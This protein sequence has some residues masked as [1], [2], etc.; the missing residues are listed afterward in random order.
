MT[1]KDE[2]VLAEARGQLTLPREDKTFTPGAGSFDRPGPLAAGPFGRTGEGGASAGSSGSSGVPISIRPQK[3]QSKKICRLRP[4]SEAHLVP[5]D[6]MHPPAKIDDKTLALLGKL[7]REKQSVLEWYNAPSSSSLP[8]PPTFSASQE[9]GPREKMEWLVKDLPEGWK[10]SPY[11]SEEATAKEFRDRPAR[12]LEFWLQPGHYNKEG[13]PA[14]DEARTRWASNERARLGREDLWPPPWNFYRDDSSLSKSPVA[15]EALEE[16]CGTSPGRIYDPPKPEQVSELVNEEVDH[17][18]TNAKA[19]Y[20]RGVWQTDTSHHARNKTVDPESLKGGTTVVEAKDGKKTLKM[21][22][23]FAG[24]KRKASVGEELR[25]LCT[26]EG[27]GLQIFEVDVLIGG[28]EHDLLDKSTQEDWLGRLEDCEFD[29]IL[30][31]PPCGSWSRANWANNDGP[32]PC[33]NRKFPMGNPIHQGRCTTAGGQRKLI[34]S[35]FHSSDNDSTDQPQKGHH[36]QVH[37]RA[38]GGLGQDGCRRTGKYLATRRWS[39]GGLWRLPVR[40]SRRPS[41]PVSGHR[42]EEADPSILRH[43]LDG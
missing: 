40:C 32:K 14:S 39:T 25:E 31:S 36:C 16:P 11:P 2:S 13:N 29:C 9:F 20:D 30:V 27:Y 23:F 18:I 26:K 10:S 22:Y 7:A 33:R 17:F 37:P 28:S 3:L 34:Y 15:T 1:W 12:P 43:S 19:A 8:P 38:P 24:V 42:Q 5:S 6:N 4:Q 41:M 35:F 21:A